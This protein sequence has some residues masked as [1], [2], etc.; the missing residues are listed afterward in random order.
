MLW[1]SVAQRNLVRLRDVVG[2][3]GPQ[4]LAETHASPPQELE[5]S[6]EGALR[7]GAPRISLVLFDEV[8][9]NSPGGLA[10]D[11]IAESARCEAPDSDW[12]EHFACCAACTRVPYG[13]PP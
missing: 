5:R 13:W 9:L 2:L 12:R 6:G 7:S 8:W 11:P 3:D 1:V 10:D 4:A